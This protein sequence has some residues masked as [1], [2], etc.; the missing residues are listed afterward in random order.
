MNHII[1]ALLVAG[2][3]TWTPCHAYCADDQ[4]AEARP[5]VHVGPAPEPV[6]IPP[7]APGDL[8]V[9]HPVLIQRV[10]DDGEFWVVLTNR[11]DILWREREERVA[12]REAMRRR[13]EANRNGPPKRPFRVK[14]PQKKTGGA[15]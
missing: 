3:I 4:Y 10:S 14:T 5:A 15:K 8:S 13:A 9:M 2:A 1:T 11:M 12:R 7:A 6:H